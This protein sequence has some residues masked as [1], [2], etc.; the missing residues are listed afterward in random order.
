MAKAAAAGHR[1]VLVTATNGEL[2]EPTPGVLA[3]GEKL[4]ERR[5]EELAL[6]ATALGA[7]EP[8]LLGYHDSGMMGEPS[9]S[10]PACFWQA[11]VDRAAEQLA[12]LLADLRVDTLTIYDER[13]LYG[14]PDHIQVHRVGLATAHLL[15]VEHVF[16][17]TVSREL[18][19]STFARVAAE[20]GEAAVDVNA[21]DV[22]Q[23]E[24]FE[25]FGV[26]HNDLAYCVNVAAQI[27][28][29]RAAMAAH[30]S[31]IPDDSFFL[32]LPGPL[33]AEIFGQEWY[34]VP[35][36]TGTGGPETVDLLPGL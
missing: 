17:A 33:F 23:P 7:E 25:D 20:M 29:K 27:E 6:A 30:R 32:R 4:W 31:Q 9:N 36:R 3:P 16:E 21:D 8:R 12:E 26:I 11:D 2:G 14:H 24:E 28:A 35:G 13:G 15:G 1:V 34:A 22:P 18:A 10:D 19:Q 5:L